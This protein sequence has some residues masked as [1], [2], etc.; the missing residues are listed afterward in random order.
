MWFHY[1]PMHFT[2]YTWNNNIQ[3]GHVLTQVG[4]LQPG[5]YWHRPITGP[6]AFTQLK[7]CDEDPLGCRATVSLAL[8]Q[9]TDMS[10]IGALCRPKPSQKLSSPNAC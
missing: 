3:T 5:P 6:Q 8:C 1:W 2:L 9:H 7:S 10:I 4:K